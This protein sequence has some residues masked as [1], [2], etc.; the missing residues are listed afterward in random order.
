MRLKDFRCDTS[1]ALDAFPV[2]QCRCLTPPPCRIQSGQTQTHPRALWTR[3]SCSLRKC[4]MARQEQWVYPQHPPASL[5]SAWSHL[6]RDSPSYPAPGATTWLC[7]K[8]LL[9]RKPEDPLDRRNLKQKAS[10]EE[11]L[12]LTTTVENSY[13]QELSLSLP[14]SPSHLSWISK[15]EKYITFR[16]TPII[17]P[18]TLKIR[19]ALYGVCFSSPWFLSRRWRTTW[20]RRNEYGVWNGVT[21]LPTGCPSTATACRP[22][23][24]RSPSAYATA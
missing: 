19:W 23:P 12:L 21:C 7:G 8:I 1:T 18:L 15:P 3:M 22:S 24:T 14:T 4:G 2:Y 11:R 5:W 20:S 10:Q 13:A 17:S 16:S 6:V 9:I